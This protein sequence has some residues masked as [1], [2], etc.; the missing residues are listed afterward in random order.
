VRKSVARLLAVFGV[1]S[2]LLWAAMPA[3]A[4]A[5]A[6]ARSAMAEDCGCCETAML[7][8]GMVCPGCQSGLHAERETS[9]APSVTAMA[10]LL[11]PAASFAGIDPVPVEPP[12]RRHASRTINLEAT[13]FKQ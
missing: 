11:T 5:G 3:V 4:L 1:L 9:A 2:A 8:G 13:E 10:W 7:A 12:P 6:T